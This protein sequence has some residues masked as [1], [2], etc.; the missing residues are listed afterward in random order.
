MLRGIARVMRVLPVSGAPIAL[1]IAALAIVSAACATTTR[2]A[3]SASDLNGAGSVHTSAIDGVWA[4]HY[5]CSQGLTGLDL[6]IQG[7]GS[8]G[9]LRVTLSFYPL[10]SNPGIP[11]GIAIYHGTYYSESRIVLRPT[12]W[13]L[14]PRTYVLVDFSGRI[15]AGRFHGTVS[16]DCTTFSARRP[17][18]H[19]APADVAGRWK[20]SYLGCAQG[21]SG[22]RLVIWR[23]A[24]GGLRA[25][26]SFYA[27]PGNP[28]VPAGSY[29]M[30]G[31]YFPGGIALEGSHWI[32][33]PAGY[34]LL[35]LAGTS[36]RSGVNR[37]SGSIA[38]CSA[39]SAFSLRRS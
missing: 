31:F 6:H 33:R 36:P 10:P 5:T 2:T 29:A 3:S 34:R 17:K 28:S 19:P 1:G 22:M 9:A 37:L 11:V 14:H 23:R 39:V 27:L 12:R 15:S 32:R 26:F 30:T 21:P 24:A 35:D 4:G 18:G 38:G 20:G 8:G 7:T 16:P 13:I 25:R